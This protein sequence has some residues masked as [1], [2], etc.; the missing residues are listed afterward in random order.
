MLWV[1]LIT[2]LTREG[3]QCLLYNQHCI[4]SPIVYAVIK[5]PVELGPCNS[6][7]L[8]LYV[9]VHTHTFFYTFI[10]SVKLEVKLRPNLKL[11]YI[12]VKTIQRILY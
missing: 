10:L 11:N 9:C 4:P 8:S 3:I 1:L 2:Q 7:H 5:S 12:P 6:Q